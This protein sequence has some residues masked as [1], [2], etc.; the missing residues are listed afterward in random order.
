MT[1]KEF[2]EMI[3]N[4]PIISFEICIECDGLGYVDFGD[5]CPSCKGSGIY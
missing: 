2:I 1:N 4:T 5:I 3:K